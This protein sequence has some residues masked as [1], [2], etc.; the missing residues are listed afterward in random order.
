MVLRGPSSECNCPYL[1][2]LDFSLRTLL[3]SWWDLIMDM[4]DFVAMDLRESIV[5]LAGD[6]DIAR[7][8][9]DLADFE[10]GADANTE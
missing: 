7:E 6:A 1:V 5:D 4:V 8:E 2:L 10:D 3:E 9:A